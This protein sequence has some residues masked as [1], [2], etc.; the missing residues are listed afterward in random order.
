[1]NKV[2]KKILLYFLLVILSISSGIFLSIKN[3]EDYF[4]TELDF[5]ELTN[6]VKVYR[7]E[8][9]IPT[10]IADNT[11]DLFFEQGFEFARD[12]LWQAEFYRSVA[13]GELSRLFG[14]DLLDSDKFLRTLKLKES[15]ILEYNQAQ[16]IR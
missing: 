12:R 14:P 2:V 9:G 1:M 7:N 16:I 10:I 5:V 15:A 3:S 4:V 8:Y 13:N 11:D 6:D